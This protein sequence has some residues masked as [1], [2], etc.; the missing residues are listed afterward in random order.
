MID[1]LDKGRNKSKNLGETRSNY[2]FSVKYNLLLNF[3][4]K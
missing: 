4:I 3:E 1:W 2:I